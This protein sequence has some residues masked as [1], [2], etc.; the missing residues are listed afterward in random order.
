MKVTFL[1]QSGFLIKTGSK[2]L[3]FDPFISANDLNDM[4]P[5]DIVCDYVLIT[6]GHQDHVLDA[7]AIAKNNEAQIISNWEIVAWYKE[8]GI[9]GHP[10]NHG[11]AWNFDFGK[12]KSVNAVHSSGLPDGSY[13]GS[14]GGFVI[15]NDEGCFYHAGDTALTMDMKLLPLIAP[16]LDFAILPIGD[17]FTMG[18]ED[19]AIAAEFIECDKIIACHYDTFGYIK[20]D[21]DA[22]KQA[23]SKRQKELIFL[24][25]GVETEF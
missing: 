13:G 10:L 5:L 6:H 23:F 19:A 25:I 12:V 21:H 24:E 4:D 15:S 17:N 9:K 8:K 22:A 20:V 11:G 18:Y 16:K 2:S 7:E 1:G 3:L 14:A